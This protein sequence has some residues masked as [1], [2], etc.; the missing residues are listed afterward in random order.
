[1]ERTSHDKKVG[2]ARD[3]GLRDSA[4]KAIQ[5]DAFG[6]PEVLHLADVPEPHAGKGQVRL[7]LKAI[8]VNPFDAKVRSGAM[9]Q[10]FKTRLP[11]I[12]GSEVAGVVDE[13]GEGVSAF[14][15]GDEVFG[16]SESG[17]YAELAVARVVA[18]KPQGMSWEQAAA[19]PVAGETATRVLDLL[20]LKK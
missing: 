6:G 15:N 9:E 12:L 7:R 18:P 16:A 1:M 13:V 11:T 19:L 8:G 3:Q 14:K 2:A 4:M 10:Q 5:F 20:Q 17:A